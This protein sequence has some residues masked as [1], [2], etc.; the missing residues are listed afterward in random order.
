MSRL[1]GCWYHKTPLSLLL[2][3]LSGLYRLLVLL[4]RQAYH[5]GLLR[6]RRVESKV[7][8]V[9]NIT[10]GGTGKTPLVIWLVEFL[11][12]QGFTPGIVSRGYRA[13]T[14][15]FPQR[16]EI[17]SDPRVMGDEA[18]LLARRGGCPVVIDPDRAR[19]ADL[20][21]A[22]CNVIISDDGLQ[23]YALGRDVEI[24]VVDGVRRFGN[25]FCLPAGPLREPLNRLY[26]VDLRVCNGGK[27]GA[28]EFRMALH[29]LGI[30]NLQNAAIMKTADHFKAKT[31]HAI[32]GIGHPARFFNQL[33]SAGVDV[34]EHAF[35]DHHDFSAH[36]LQFTDDFEILMTEKDAVKCLRFAR[37][38]HWYMPIQAILDDAFPSRLLS[39]LRAPSHG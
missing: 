10:V 37:P 25:N 16:V 12:A 15:R 28:D 13:M 14:R 18:V 27:P 17:D 35:P 4:R 34:I 8:V 20:L 30:Y 33:R 32:A 21:A 5:Q 39:L 23:H 22:E 1:E 31:V 26:S 7:I 9:G 6:V 11:K 3:P 24:A 38:H 19:A 29:P 2:L 36:D